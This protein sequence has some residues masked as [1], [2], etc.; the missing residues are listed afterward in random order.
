MHNPEQ[1]AERGDEHR[2]AADAPVAHAH[3]PDAH[4]HGAH[5][6]LPLA[7]R[8]R[9]L[10]AAYRY[11]NLASHHVL[12]F[13]V[14]AVLLVYFT[15]MLLFLALRWAI[16]PNIDLYKPDIE[17]AASRALGNPVTISRVY[18][19]WRGLHP[20]LFLGDVRLRDREGRQVLALP[21]V[22]AT[23]SW[24][25][26]A[27]LE[28]RFDNLEINRPE[29]DVRRTPDGVFWVAGVRID[30]NRKEEGNGSGAD[31]LL[32]QREIVIRE[33]RV[34]WTDQLRAAP[35]LELSNVTMALEN[36]WTSHRFALKASPPAGVSAPLDVRARFSHPAFGARASDPS[37][38]KGELYADLRNTDLASWKQYISYPFNVEAGR[39]SVRAWINFD[40][41]R[42]AGFTADLGLAGVS[43]RLA[44]DAPPLDLARVSGRLSAREEIKP[45]VEEGKPTFGALGHSI[46]IEHFSVV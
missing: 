46:G 8:W 21:S 13:T 44:P 14:K 31:W 45:G 28:P 4:A 15:F 23:L 42:L 38:W 19:S 32:R 33:G 43:A 5:E 37:R 40:H 36:R 16:L 3:A 30:P 2:Q 1:Q 41:A 24:W 34:S 6:H 22:S 7:E 27:A 10:R 12:G 18:A 35:L 26:V 20:N 17:R 25:S 39:G 9:R 11:A 29:L